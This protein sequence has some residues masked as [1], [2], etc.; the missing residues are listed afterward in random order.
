MAEKCYIVDG[1][2]HDGTIRYGKEFY[3]GDDPA[4]AQRIYDILAN[5]TEPEYTELTGGVSYDG[6][7]MA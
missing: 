2:G 1:Y 4:E 7:F 5:K 3:M 6:F